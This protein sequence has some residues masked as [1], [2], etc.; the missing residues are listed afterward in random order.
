[1]GRLK[2]T[3]GCVKIDTSSFL[4]LLLYIVYVNIFPVFFYGENGLQR[5][6]KNPH[7]H[8]IS[9]EIFFS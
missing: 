3:G 9:E 2:V 7:L 5:C 8:I 4:P 1:M 6:E